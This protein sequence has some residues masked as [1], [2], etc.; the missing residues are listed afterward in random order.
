MLLKLKKKNISLILGPLVI[1]ALSFFTL[2]KQ[3]LIISI[4]DTLEYFMAMDL[5]FSYPSNLMNFSD[6]DRN[7]LTQSTEQKLYSIVASTPKILRYKFSNKKNLLF[8]RIDLDVKFI[9][10]QKIMGDRYKAIKNHV[11][12]EPTIVGAK[13]RYKGKQNKNEF[14]SKT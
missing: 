8:E 5:G 11:L 3:D 1:L 6:G 10:Y 4:H 9:D 14:S 7:A 12:H 13:I 2:S